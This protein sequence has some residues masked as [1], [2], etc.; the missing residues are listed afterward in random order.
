MSRLNLFAKSQAEK[1]KR[2]RFRCVHRHNGF[3]HPS[4]YDQAN[5]IIERIGFTDIESSNLN[6]PFGVVYTYCIKELEGKLYKRAVTRDELYKGIYDKALLE[7]FIKDIDGFTR[8]VVHYGSDRKFDLPM[9]RSRAEYW[10]LPF[11][12]YKFIYITD[13][14]NILKNKFRLHSNR[15]ESACE[16]FHIPAK[17]HKLK[18]DVWLKMITGNPKLMQEALDYIMKHNVE[19]VVSLERLWKRISKYTLV[20]KRSI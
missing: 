9:L 18:P 16:F 5:G 19:D 6:A 7:Q 11:P 20:G 13:T 10:R 12:Q 8:L 1:K 2:L 14:W 17:Q 4:C 15:L 3:S